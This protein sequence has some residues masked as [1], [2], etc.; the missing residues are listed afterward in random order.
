MPQSSRIRRPST[1]HFMT[2]SGDFA[3]RPDEPH[4]HS[5]ILYEAGGR[6]LPGLAPFSVFAADVDF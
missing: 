5:V 3:R 2:G 6:T 4:V 1:A